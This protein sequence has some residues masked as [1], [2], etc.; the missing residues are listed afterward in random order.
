MYSCERVIT[1]IGVLQWCCKC[2]APVISEFWDFKLNRTEESAPS[3][4]RLAVLTLVCVIANNIKLL[5]VLKV[6]KVNMHLHY[7]DGDVTF[8]FCHFCKQGR[9]QSNRQAYYYC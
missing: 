3:E 2:L 9:K 4:Q 8:C 6:L 1:A 5:S 7:N